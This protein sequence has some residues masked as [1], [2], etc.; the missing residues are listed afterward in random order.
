M[1]QS[2][3]SRARKVPAEVSRGEKAT[4]PETSAHG[5]EVRLVV[6]QPDVLEHPNRKNAIERFIEPPIIL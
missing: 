5:L 4:S 1:C 6:L 3:F 2:W